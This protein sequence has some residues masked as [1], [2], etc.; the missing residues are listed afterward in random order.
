MVLEKLKFKSIK[1]FFKNNT[2]LKVLN[3]LNEILSIKNS[4]ELKKMLL[5]LGLKI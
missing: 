4:I 3:N 2:N 1:T 5:G